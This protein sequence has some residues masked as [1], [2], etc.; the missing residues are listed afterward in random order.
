LVLG[1]GN[2]L[3]SDDGV[4]PVILESLLQQYGD[5]DSRVEFLDGGTQGLS[6]LGCLS[7]R[8]T[9]IILDALQL[10]K[11]AGA[12]SALTL[13]QVQELGMRRSSTAHEG[14]AGELLA[15]AALL[16]DLPEQVFVVGVEPQRLRTGIGLSA[17]VLAAVPEAAARARQLIADALVV[18]NPSALETR[19]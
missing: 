12:V 19:G 13:Q 18:Q 9:L 10:G 5:Q 14:N 6:L 1:L 15:A 8:Q 4:G 2:P 3:L 17:P 11:E 7:G 16:G